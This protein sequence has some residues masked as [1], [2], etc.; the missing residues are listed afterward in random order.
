MADEIKYDEDMLIKLANFRSARRNDRRQL[1]W[2][3]SVAVWAVLGGLILKGFSLP[4]WP[5]PVIVLIFVVIV[6]AHGFWIGLNWVR[7]ER[8]MRKAFFYMDRLHKQVIGEWP[9]TEPR[10][11]DVVKARLRGQP[12][13]EK[14]YEW[15]LL[16]GRQMF[17]CLADPMYLVEIMVTAGLAAYWVGQQH[18]ALIVAPH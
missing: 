17:E 2:R 11:L 12:I 13:P 5:L 10:F 18:C 16:R 4:C 14:S 6:L 15:P 7:S 1:E 8:D 9:P 3:F